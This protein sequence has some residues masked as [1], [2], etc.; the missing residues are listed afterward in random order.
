M[1]ERL[2]SPLVL[3]TALTASATPAFS[4][5]DSEAGRR[6]L[7]HQVIDNNWRVTLRGNTR[8]SANPANDRGRVSDA[9]DMDHMLLQLQRPAE[10]E[11]SLQRYLG[12]LTDQ[13]SPNYH[14]WLTPAQ[15]GEHFGPSPSDVT[16]VS[17]WLQA[18]GFTVNRIYP[19]NVLIDFSGTAG[20]VRQ[21]FRTEIH[22]LN[23][24]GES[25]IA[26]MS[27]PEIPAALA[28]AI[29]GV[30]SMNNFMPHSMKRARATYTF[31]VGS[32]VRQAVVPADLATIYKLNPLYAAG[33]A[34]QGQTIAVIE[35][36]N[37][38]DEADWT[39]FRKKFGLSIYKSGSFTQVHPGSCTDPEVVGGNASEAILDA[40]WA[41]AAAP[42]AA[43]QLASCR[44]TTTTFG[45][46]I[47][48]QN[49]L[50]GDTAPPAL[51]S[52]SYGACEAEN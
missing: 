14:Q 35:N 39:T 20:Q 45:G 52:I 27:D 3:I 15:F 41:S 46:L 25:H 50:N 36:T 19:N 23:V 42:A 22:Q 16:A 4:Q 29:V 33:V 2:L 49:L 11:Q 13:A 17:D 26:N 18:Q 12:E 28:P 32:G 1:Q 51:I 7:I 8:A 48:L 24:A 40:E 9:L 43:I 21:A 34:G 31:P 47:A 38:Y 30:V 6:P 10:A 5:T 37:V 44:D